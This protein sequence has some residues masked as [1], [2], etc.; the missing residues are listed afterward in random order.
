MKY[1]DVN[2]KALHRHWGQRARWVMG[3]RV[4]IV[5]HDG[6]YVQEV[7]VDIGNVGAKWV[8]GT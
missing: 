4:G 2:D 5:G 1:G 8:L 7:Q 3:T 6:Y